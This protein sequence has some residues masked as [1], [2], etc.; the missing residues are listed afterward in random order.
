MTSKELPGDFES[1]ISEIMTTQDYL[2]WREGILSV[3]P[4]Q[5]GISK[6]DTV[7]VY[8][9]IM[10]IGM[11]NPQSL[12]NWAISLS[13]FLTG[14]ASFRPTVGGGVVGLGQYPEVA[15]AANEI[16]KISQALL[17]GTS[18]TQDFSLPE[19]GVVQFLFLTTSGMHVF[20]SQLEELQRPENPYKQ[21]L[22]RFGFIRQFGDQILA[23][24]RQIV[25]K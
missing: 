12:C 10:D 8:G 22:N 5:V 20:E 19:P 23:R 18:P 3:E 4:G 11:I 16:V 6:N 1:K 21:L 25:F 9:V 7:K 17:R 14:E 24:K 2:N 13:A 15:Q